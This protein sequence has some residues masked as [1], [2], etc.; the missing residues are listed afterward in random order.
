[1]HGKKCSCEFVVPG[2]RRIQTGTTNPHEITRIK[3]ETRKR[4]RFKILPRPR[5][6]RGYA[7][8]ALTQNE[9][10]TRKRNQ[11]ALKLRSGSSKPH[12]RE[13]QTERSPD[14]LPFTIYY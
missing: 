5:S 3:K 6:L 10:P 2:F 13:V 12:L 8:K 7:L 1:M 11:P 14:A 9:R 4:N